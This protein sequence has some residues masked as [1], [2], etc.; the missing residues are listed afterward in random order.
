MYEYIKHNKV[1]NRN[2]K[3]KE[4]NVSIFKRSIEKIWLI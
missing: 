1:D 4:K 3:K 2:K